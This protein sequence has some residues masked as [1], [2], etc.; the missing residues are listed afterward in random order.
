MQSNVFELLRRRLCSLSKLVFVSKGTMKNSSFQRL[1]QI[2]HLVVATATSLCDRV[3]GVPLMSVAKSRENFT[4]G[5][6]PRRY[7][8]VMVLDEFDIHP[9]KGIRSK[10]RGLGEILL[11]NQ[12]LHALTDLFLHFS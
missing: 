8:Q 1:L 3:G 12:V 10:D 9:A 7:K 2:L 11:P 5:P 6:G 4:S